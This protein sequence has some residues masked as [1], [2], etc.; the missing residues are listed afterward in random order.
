M[1]TGG[2]V[3]EPSFAGRTAVPA[4]LSLGLGMGLWAAAPAS[5]RQAPESVQDF[6]Y[7]VPVEEGLYAVRLKFAEPEYEPLFARPFSVQINGREVLR[8]FSEC[9]DA[10]GFRQA[11]DRVFRYVV[12]DAEGRIVLRFSGGFE[13]GQQTDEAL[14]QAIEVLPGNGPATRVTCGSAT[15][16]VDWNRFVWGRDGDACQGR[17]IRS[18]RPVAQATPTR[19]DQALYQTARCAPE[20]SYALSLPPV[21][22]MSTTSSPNCGSRRP[23]GDPWTS[24]STAARSG[25]GGTPLLPPANAAWRSICGPCW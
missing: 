1:I 17:A 25:R 3:R 19:Y 4:V 24:R 21:Y 16:F 9:Q 2:A 23:A 11:G 7:D 10:R 5:A 22:T 13:P 6:A 15:D 20:L 14:V 18:S 8:D 12:P